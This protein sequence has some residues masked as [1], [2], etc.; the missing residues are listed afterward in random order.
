MGEQREVNL[1]V[2]YY[3]YAD[4]KALEGHL[5]G[6]GITILSAAQDAQRVFDDAVRL[7]ADAV[8]LCPQVTGYRREFIDDLLYRTGREKPIPTIGWVDA[9]SDDGRAMVANGAKGYV[10][11]PMDPT[12][13]NKA[14]RL[15][16]QAIEQ[17]AREDRGEVAAVQPVAA[18]AAR[19]WQRKAVV[20]W[21]SKGG[22]S[23]RTTLA[24]NLAVALSHSKLGNTPTAL[25]DMDM[26]KADAHT[27]LGFTTNL[28]R[29]RREGLP[30]LERG[31]YDL[32]LRLG[33]VW[34]TRGESALTPRM[35]DNYT[36]PWMPDKAHLALL[37]G[38]F[39]PAHADAPIFRDRRLVYEIGKRIID[40]MT[41]RYAFVVLDIGQDMTAPLHRAAI[42]SADEVVVTVPP[43][44]TAVTDVAN[45][46]PALRKHFGDLSKFKLV[47][48]AYDDGFGMSERE[49]IKEVGLPK[50]ITIPHDAAVAS[51]SINEGVPFVL[52]DDGPLGESVRE[53]A[54]IYLPALAARRKGGKGLGSLVSGIKSALVRE[55]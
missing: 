30:L 22:G 35:L 4:L 42:E 9:Q 17:V 23:T 45:A 8:L 38:L 2:G 53:L 14:V 18:S 39:N 20:P 44:W 28:D 19:S 47:V 51:L 55:A 32:L 34:E 33:E 48:T 50:L 43:Q 31:L 12:Q 26:T 40:V 46:L 54:G 27:M 36:V 16:R 10:T 15:I 41:Q 29:A 11:L 24:V 25:L 52:T 7:E 5:Q 6:M 49:I 37:P 1:V 13:G 21:I 3:N